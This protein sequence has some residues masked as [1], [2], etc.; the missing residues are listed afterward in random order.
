MIETWKPIQLELQK[1]EIGKE[2]L[3]FVDKFGREKDSQFSGLTDT[4]KRAIIP[5]LQ[6]SSIKLGDMVKARVVDATQNTL[7]CELI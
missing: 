2:H 4:N 5:R 3:V 6:N 7:F 1:A